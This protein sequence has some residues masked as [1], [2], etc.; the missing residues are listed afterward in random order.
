VT[1]VIWSTLLT[2]W[3]SPNGQKLFILRFPG[4]YLI[5]CTDAQGVCVR[6]RNHAIALAV[7]DMA[8]PR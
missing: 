7:V 6:D 8:E 2:Q 3:S 4:R 5:V 1:V